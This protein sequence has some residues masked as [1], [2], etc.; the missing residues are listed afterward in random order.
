MSSPAVELRV[1]GSAAARLARTVELWATDQLP[2]AI[3]AALTDT[4]REARD[5]AR[6][7]LGKHFKLRN[8]ALG[9]A[10]HY[11]PA[12]KRDRPPVAAVV[13]RPWAKFLAEHAI[14]ELRRPARRAIAVPTRI[15]QAQ[16]TATGRV[17]AR[18]KPRALGERKGFDPTAYREQARIVVHRPNKLGLFFFLKHGVRIKRTWPLPEEVGEVV[19]AR[20][21]VNFE[22]RAAQAFATAR[23]P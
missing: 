9:Q 17:P 16:R 19:R 8:R 14:G 15:V 4:A 22:R 5:V 20:L 3:A 18:L 12:S 11:L 13:L 2:F 21:G 7:R 23:R 10:L 1:D 6:E